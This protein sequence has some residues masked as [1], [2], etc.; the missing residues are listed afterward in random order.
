MCVNQSLTRAPCSALDRQFDTLRLNAA[1][2]CTFEIPVL[3]VNK[4]Q[5]RLN[6][7]QAGCN[8]SSVTCDA[9]F[10][11]WDQDGGGSLDFSELRSALIKCMKQARQYAHEPDPAREQ[12]LRLEKLAVLADEAAKATAAADALELSL[13]TKRKEME[14]RTD[15]RLGALLQARL[16]KPG[17]VVIKWASSKG[18]LG[19]LS[20]SDFRRG[21]LSLFAGNSGREGGAVVRHGQSSARTGMLPPQQQQEQQQQQQQ[22]QQKQPSQP[23]QPSSSQA[24]SSAP[25]SAPS[26]SPSPSPAPAPAPS[27]SGNQV[28]TPIPRRR[29]FSDSMS[30]SVSVS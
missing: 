21:V 15:L 23:P 1:E 12:V 16:F 20:K 22:Q 28:V 4:A 30:V 17:Q 11:L 13:D 3:A 19:E 27:L 7:R 24:D 18:A 2:G 25:A 29:S 10:D 26:P 8:I 14:A 6:L 9:L 5:L